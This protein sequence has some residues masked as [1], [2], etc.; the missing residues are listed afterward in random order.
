[1]LRY[2]S[3]LTHRSRQSFL[4]T[5]SLV[6][7]AFDQVTSTLEFVSPATGAFVTRLEVTTALKL[8]KK[9]NILSTFKSLLSFHL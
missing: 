2:V 5:D 4:Q 8:S 9:R 6:L 7:E 3:M 1:M